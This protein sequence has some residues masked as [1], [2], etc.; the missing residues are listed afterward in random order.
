MNEN[1][2]YRRTKVMRTSRRCSLVRARTYRHPGCISQCRSVYFSVQLARGRSWCITSSSGVNN[3]DHFVLHCFCVVFNLLLLFLD[4][5]HVTLGLILFGFCR[6]CSR[7]FFLLPL[8]SFA[9]QSL[10]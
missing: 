3:R 6:C 1:I 9:L 5:I 4:R 2:L 10:L 7:G 8:D